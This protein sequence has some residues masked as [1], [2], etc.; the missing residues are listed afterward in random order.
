[1]IYQAGA[2][3][4]LT[5]KDSHKIIIEYIRKNKNIQSEID[6]IVESMSNEELEK[7]ILSNTRFG[8]DQK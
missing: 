3:Y 5:D 2:L 7:F 6:N 4:P 8:M 1:M